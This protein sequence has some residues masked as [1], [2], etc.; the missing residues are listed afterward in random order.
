MRKAAIFKVNPIKIK[1]CLKVRNNAE[2]VVFVTGIKP[3]NAVT[4]L[5]AA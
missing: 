5:L 2:A 3:R 4:I 1:I